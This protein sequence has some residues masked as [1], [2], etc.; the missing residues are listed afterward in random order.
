M[1]DLEQVQHY[2]IHQIFYICMLL[3]MA[4]T[5][6]HTTVTSTSTVILVTKSII[7]RPTKADKAARKLLEAE[8]RVRTICLNLS[9]G[10][11]Y[12]ELKYALSSTGFL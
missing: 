12:K 6:T 5:T 2:L 10:S 3:T 1:T 7:D 11:H 9:V 8:V 4:S